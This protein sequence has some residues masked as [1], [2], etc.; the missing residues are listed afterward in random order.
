MVLIVLLPAARWAHTNTLGSSTK[1]SNRM[2]SVSFSAFGLSSNPISSQNQFFLYLQQQVLG[3]PSTKCYPPR[4]PPISPRQGPPTW[5][6]GQARICRLPYPCSPRK[7]Q[8][9]CPQGCVCLRNSNDNMGSLIFFCSIGATY[10]KP[11]RQGVNH[12][13]FQRGLRSTAEERVGKRCGNLRVLNSYWINQ[14]GVYKYYEVIL[15]DPNHKAVSYLLYV[16]W[17]SCSNFPLLL[18]IRSAVMP[19]LTGSSPPFTSAARLADLP[20]SE[21]RTVVWAKATVTTTPLLAP[22]GRNTTPS[23]SADTVD[24]LF[25][26]F[27]SFF[28]RIHICCYVLCS[29]HAKI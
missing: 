25:Q 11:V 19:E 9:A 5:I 22:P 8:K 23:A 18:R 24:R 29:F 28:H 6:Q 16:Y 3:I 12:L 27:L 15:V 20:A 4:L 13:K 7:P 17:S 14:D 26:L 2:S 1:R 21:S 10:G